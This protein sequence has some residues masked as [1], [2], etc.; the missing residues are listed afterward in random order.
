MRSFLGYGDVY[1]KSVAGKLL[2]GVVSISG[3]ILLAFP[4]SIIVD[5]FN[6]EYLDK[7]QAEAGLP[8][9]EFRGGGLF[10]GR[11]RRKV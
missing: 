11:R 5:N 6:R 8:P 1:P 4:I 7:K 3:V 10:G 9:M 2:A